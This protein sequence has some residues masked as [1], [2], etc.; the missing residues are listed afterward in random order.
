MIVGVP[1]E[2]KTDEYRVGIIPVGV[3]TLARHGHTV[4]LEQGT[5]VGS[6]I[7]GDGARWWSGASPTCVN[8]GE[9]GGPGYG[10]SSRSRNDT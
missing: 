1:K 9:P 3:E 2:V 7:S 5:G 6:G 8:R 10:G 4:L